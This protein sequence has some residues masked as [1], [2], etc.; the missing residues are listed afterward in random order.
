M[1]VEVYRKRERRREKE[2]KKRRGLVKEIFRGCRTT[3]WTFM[4]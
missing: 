2:I 1:G 4:F 3:I